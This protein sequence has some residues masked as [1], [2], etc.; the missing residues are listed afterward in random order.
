MVKLLDPLTA[1][2][3]KT[4]PFSLTPYIGRPLISLR[5]G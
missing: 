4:S 2:P 3:K 5:N 1:L